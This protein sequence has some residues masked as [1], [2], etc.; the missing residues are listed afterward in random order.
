MFKSKTVFVVGAGASKEANLPIGK[1]LTQK[2]AELVNFHIEFNG[3]VKSGN[4]QIYECIRQMIHADRDNWKDQKLIQSGRA[5]A[6]AMALAPSIDTFLHT[7][8]DNREF[9]LM[10]KLGIAKAILLAESKSL[11]APTHD[12][13]V[14][15]SMKKL[16][17]TWY[18]S[19]AQHLFSGIQANEADKVF[20]NVGFIVFN[21]DRC[22]EIFLT[23]ALSVYFRIE[24]EEA[25]SI[26]NKID[27]VHPYGSLGDYAD[28]THRGV[29]FGDDD[30]NLLSVAKRILTF[31]ESIEDE[32]LVAKIKEM[33]REAETLVFL[34][35][36]FHEQNMDLLGDE[37]SKL[38]KRTNIERV[39][40]TTHGLSSSDAQVVKN[41][42]AHLLKGRPQ[43]P[44]DDYSILT[45]G[46]ECRHL[47]A[48]YWRSLSAS[49]SVQGALTV[50]AEE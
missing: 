42:I 16:A 48:E 30:C 49:A 1:E 34:G 43:R 41:Q 6:E 17:D 32:N 10:G 18:V 3:T 37:V 39:Y 8:R 2:I 20:E 12:R 11:L 44:R 40:A 28:T 24:I 31:S 35:F 45:Y 38:E 47:F 46:G 13:S 19:L 50:A 15:F 23:R 4:P 29:V 7:H 36:G 25:K 9:V 26:V 33:V 21:Y 27:I 14:P 22:L 5:V